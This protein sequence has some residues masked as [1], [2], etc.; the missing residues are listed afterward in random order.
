MGR[1]TKQQAYQ[2]CWNYRAESNS[3]AKGAIERIDQPSSYGRVTDAVARG[4][5][6]H[7][8]WD[9]GLH[10]VCH[11]HHAGES[12]QHAKVTHQTTSLGG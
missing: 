5:E 6:Q 10:E 9:Q 8:N 4:H 3:D 7:F 1:K 11:H 12:R 2:C